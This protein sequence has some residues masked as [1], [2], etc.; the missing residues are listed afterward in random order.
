MLLLRRSGSYSGTS[1]KWT[2]FLL[3]VDEE[4]EDVDC[5]GD[6]ERAE[7]V[8][9]EEEDLVLGSVAAQRRSAREP[10]GGV[11]RSLGPEVWGS[12]YAVGSTAGQIRRWS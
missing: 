10:V 7:E 12:W 4:R 6:E 8:E 11:R 9:E 5:E 2:D 3:A 1:A